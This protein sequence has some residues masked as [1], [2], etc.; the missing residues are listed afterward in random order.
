[1]VSG[2]R[3]TGDVHISSAK[4][5]FYLEKTHQNA[6]HISNRRINILQQIA[7]KDIQQPEHIQRRE[8]AWRSRVA[9][10]MYF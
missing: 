8:P 3:V 7:R 5:T 4:S 2:L 6:T 1:M 10:K 9:F